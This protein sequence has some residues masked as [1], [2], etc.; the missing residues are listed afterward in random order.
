M[1]HRQAL[2]W[3]SEEFGVRILLAVQGRLDRL[4]RLRFSLSKFVQVN[5]HPM[6]VYGD[7]VQPIF[8]AR[9]NRAS[10]VTIRRRSCYGSGRLT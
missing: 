1:G 6:R 2:G 5:L 8:C 9:G 4:G 7:E 10:E 3:V